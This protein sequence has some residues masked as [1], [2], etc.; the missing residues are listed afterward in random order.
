MGRGDRIE[1]EERGDYIRIRRKKEKEKL[2]TVRE[3]KNGADPSA[4]LCCVLFSVHQTRSGRIKANT[5]ASRQILG[6]EK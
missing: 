5:Q 1:G 6:V 3:I 2:S 4:V